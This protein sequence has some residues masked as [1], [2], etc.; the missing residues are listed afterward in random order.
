MF[1]SVAQ[2]SPKVRMRGS[3]VVSQKLGA[4]E[5]DRGR[6]ARGIGEKPGRVP[7]SKRRV[8]LSGDRHLIVLNS[9]GGRRRLLAIVLRAVSEDRGKGNQI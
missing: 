6:L 9:T 1:D 8:C 4:K 2:T 3:F 7:E 5:G